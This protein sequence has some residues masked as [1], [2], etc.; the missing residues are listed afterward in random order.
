MY[1]D[2]T[3]RRRQEVAIIPCGLFFIFAKLFGK[4]FEK[5]ELQLYAFSLACLV[6]NN[7][8]NVPLFKR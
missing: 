7:L 1:C 8:L 2:V 3:I 5:D 4:K 6:L